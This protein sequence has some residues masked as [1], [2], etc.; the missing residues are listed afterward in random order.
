MNAVTVNSAKQNLDSLLS[1]VIANIEPTIICN[2]SG[3]KA[4]LM[5]LDEFDSWQETLY[6]LS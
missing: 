6:L 1:Q 4:V 5:S 2:D 3:E